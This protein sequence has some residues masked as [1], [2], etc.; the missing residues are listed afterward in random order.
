MS[1]PRGLRNYSVKQSNL[2]KLRFK[3]YQGSEEE[4]EQI[5]GFV[6]KRNT[7][8]QRLDARWSSGVEVVASVRE[9]GEET[10]ELVIT[11]RRR[12]DTITV[13]EFPF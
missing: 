9:S 13:S 2:K 3:N 5:L 1:I 7:P 4:F 11:I 10:K 8:E 12:I 6:L